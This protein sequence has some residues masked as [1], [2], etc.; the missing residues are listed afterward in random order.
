MC[1]GVRAYVGVMELQ[2]RAEGELSPMPVIVEI[3]PSSDLHAEAERANADLGV[4]H[5][6]AMR[7][8]PQCYH[9][10]LPHPVAVLRTAP[11]VMAQQLTMLDYARYK[12]ITPD[13]LN[14]EV[15]PTPPCA[16]SRCGRRPCFS[17]PSGLVAARPR[18]HRS[19][20]RGECAGGASI[21]STAPF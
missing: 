21:R 3:K 18:L 13:D 1:V 12:Q 8:G 20:T 16:G 6:I 2:L 11:A 15:L 4:G 9:E 7:H 5:L 14:R 17:M 19:G 10:R